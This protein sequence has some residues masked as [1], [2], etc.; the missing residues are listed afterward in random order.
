[1]SRA[2]TLGRLAYVYLTVPSQTQTQR[3]VRQVERRVAAAAEKA[4]A[5]LV[6]AVSGGLD[7]MVLLDA[8]ARVVRSRIAAVATFD[9]G[10]GSHSA[11]SAEFV[12]DEAHAR[13]VPVV[14]GRGEQLSPAESVWREARWGFL[15]RVAADFGAV[16]ATAHTEDDQVE[17]VLMRAMRGAGARG[18]AALYASSD[19]SRPFIDLSRATL[20]Q[21]ARARDVRWVSDPTN[22]DLRFFRNRIRRDLLPAL[23]Q[24]RS[25]LGG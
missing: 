21:Y 3:A 1:M 16:V 19:V 23:F 11:T 20:E 12:C 6:L 8:A 15:R 10:S 22:E 18:L 4:T 24:A 5:P 14:S 9:H 7:S 25:G 13:D 17:T 2:T